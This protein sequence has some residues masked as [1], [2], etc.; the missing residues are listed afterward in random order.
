M[1]NNNF[2]VSQNINFREREMNR[3]NKVKFGATRCQIFR[4]KCTKLDFRWDS[5]PDPAGEITVF[6]DPLAV[7][8]GSTS[9]GRGEREERRRKGENK[10][11][12]ER[13]GKEEREREGPTRL[14]STAF[15]NQISYP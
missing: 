6:P 9:K 2:Y 15:A 4:R 10:G 13:K 11:K 5:A 3:K 12:W 1:T 7:F 8:K 14:I